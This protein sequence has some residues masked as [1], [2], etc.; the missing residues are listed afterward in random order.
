MS[1]KLFREFQES[2]IES[3]VLARISIVRSILKRLLLGINQREI[4]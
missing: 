2:E 1:M 4:K 3:E